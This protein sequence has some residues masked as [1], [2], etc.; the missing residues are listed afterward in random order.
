[1]VCHPIFAF[2]GRAEDSRRGIS[3]S[4]EPSGRGSLIIQP[5]LGRRDIVF[6][7]ECPDK[8]FR[9]V[10]ADLLADGGNAFVRGGK[11]QCRHIETAAFHESGK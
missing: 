9:V 3:A 8:I 11:H 4:N 7:L 10:I 5:I 6:F 1:M 2:G